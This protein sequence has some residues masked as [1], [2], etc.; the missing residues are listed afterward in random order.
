[1]AHDILVA[2]GG[3]AGL[4]AAVGA[5]AAGWEVRVFEKAAAF[6]EAGAGLQLGPN[7]TRILREWNLLDHPALRPYE[8]P[9]LSVRDAVDGRE[10]GVLRLGATAR[11]RYAAPYLTLHRADLHTVLLDAA[12]QAGAHLH[13]GHAIAGARVDGETAQADLVG[14]TMVEADALAVADG[15]W[16]ALRTQLLGDGPAPASGHVA[17]RALLPM[18]QLPASLRQQEVQ[19]WLGPRMHL[20]RYPVRG[21]EALNIVAFIE[22]RAEAAWDQDAG[23][24]ELRAVA[25]ASCRELQALVE[26]VDHWR[27]WPVHDRPPLR[28]ENAM[29]LGRAVLLGDAAHPMRPYLAQGAGM[30][31][32][33]ALALQKVLAACSDRVLDVP[34]SLRRF[35]LDR[36][37]RCARVQARSRRN[38]WIFHAD[39]ALRLARNLSMRIGGERLLD[40]PWLYGA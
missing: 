35:A 18:A 12:A 28:S 22:G 25:R 3:I 33:D 23:D 39:G 17:Y 38:G 26:T 16:S 11:E 14:G 5:R 29:A 30:A 37:Q 20:V 10:L 21:G 19:A 27:L 1:M 36:W 9:R 4:A 7:A 8:P 6:A 15:V 40:L 34:T 13:A 31:L 32:E 2:G 24:G